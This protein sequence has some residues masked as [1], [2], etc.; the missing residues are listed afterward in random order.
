MKRKFSNLNNK[1]NTLDENNKKRRIEVNINNLEIYAK[2]QTQ[3]NL[4]TDFFET[5]LQGFKDEIINLYK[6]PSD[7]N[8]NK[9]ETKKFDDLSSDSIQLI[10]GFIEFPKDI[11]SLATTNKANHW[12]L[13]SCHIEHIHLKYANYVL[14]N[15]LKGIILFR[16]CKIEKYKVEWNDILCG[17]IS[18]ENCNL[19]D[20]L[21]DD[22]KIDPSFNKNQSLNEAAYW[23]RDLMFEAICEHPKINV[24]SYDNLAV[25]TAAINGHSSILNTIFHCKGYK[26]TKGVIDAI[27]I[28]ISSEDVDAIEDLYTELKYNVLYLNKKYYNF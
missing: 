3:T 6:P 28:A 8:L 17:S 18:E 12:M 9:V 26:F 21:Y 7:L 25:R 14:E 13:L 20:Y 19:F 10:M 1:K 5:S 4:L 23:G 11:V 15:N 24:S 27:D 16:Y 22:G 2:P